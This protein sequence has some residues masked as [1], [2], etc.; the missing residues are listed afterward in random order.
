MFSKLIKSITKQFDSDA[1]QEERI[2]LIRSYLKTNAISCNRCNSLGVPIY[3]TSNHYRCKECG[4][5]FTNS[6]HG[7]MRRLNNMAVNWTTKEQV[8]KWYDKAVERI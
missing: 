4:R 5:Q 7:L 3:G 6:N 2:E 1:F 8:K